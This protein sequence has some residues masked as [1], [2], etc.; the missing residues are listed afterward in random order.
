MVPKARRKSMELTGGCQCGKRRYRANE[1]PTSIGYCHCNMCKKAT[2]GPFALLVRFEPDSVEWLGTE[3]HTY[4]SSPIAERGFCPDCGTPLFL[5]YD[6]DAR[7]RMT[8]GSLDHP[9]GFAPT[10]HYGV[11]SR[12]PFIDCS[13]GLPE[14]ETQESF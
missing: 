13:A 5:R 3:P 11:E 4:R 1:P 6:D 12:L 10:H 8:I 14:E 2:G 7:L 9:E